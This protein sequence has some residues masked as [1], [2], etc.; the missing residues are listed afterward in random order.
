MTANPEDTF[1]DIKIRLL[2]IRPL[3]W[4]SVRVPSG[5]PLSDLH[6]VI[7]ASMGWENCHLHQ[8]EYNGMRVDDETLP[9]CQLLTVVKD[10][11][12]YEYDFGDLWVHT[13][14]LEKILASDPAWQHPRCLKGKRA[15]PPEDCG[16][17]PGYSHWLRTQKRKRGK[18][19]DP[20]HFDPEAVNHTLVEL[21]GS[22]EVEKR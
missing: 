19:H 22:A 3:I 5:I 20:E 2:E 6:W 9:V 14:T 15:C 18:K 21:G 16:G 7:Q 8:Y 12:V 11:L 10:V 1:Y 4:R 17:P 13:L